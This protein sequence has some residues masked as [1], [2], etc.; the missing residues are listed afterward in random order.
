MAETLSAQQTQ[1]KFS[2]LRDRLFT[3]LDRV[4]A[5]YRNVPARQAFSDATQAVKHTRAARRNRE[6]F[7]MP[8]KTIE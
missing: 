4:W 8:R 2:S 7:A 6:R 1:S 5:K 3:V